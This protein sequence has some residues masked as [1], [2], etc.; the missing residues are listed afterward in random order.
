[1]KVNKIGE[2]ERDRDAGS[3]KKGYTNKHA[4]LEQ[5]LATLN[6]KSFTKTIVWHATFATSLDQFFQLDKQPRPHQ[7]Q[8]VIRM[9]LLKNGQLFFY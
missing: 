1:M 9:F 2:K 3:E 7:L 6:V 4:T 8:R 5:R